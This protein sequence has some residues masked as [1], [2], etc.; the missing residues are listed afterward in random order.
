M[1]RALQHGDMLENHGA[2]KSGGRGAAARCSP[3]PRRERPAVLRSLWG[4]EM[5]AV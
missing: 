4:W 5:I 1:T 2:P 3:A